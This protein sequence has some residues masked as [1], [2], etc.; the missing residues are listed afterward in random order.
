MWRSPKKGLRKTSERVQGS[1][2][3]V[4]CQAGVAP[5]APPVASTPTRTTAV[6]RMVRR[7]TA[8]ILG[9]SSD[10]NAGIG[11]DVLGRLAL[12]ALV[13]LPSVARAHPLAPAV[14]EIRETGDG[15]ADVGW[16][17]PLARPRGAEIE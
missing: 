7:L 9:L 3:S 4:R 8:A 15:H 6:R 13:A 5:A 2:I 17:T 14:L 16:K 12:V 1:R 10:A 11:C